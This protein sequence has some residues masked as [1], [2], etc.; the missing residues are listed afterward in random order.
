M[1]FSPF[2]FITSE[3]MLTGGFMGSA[4]LKIDIPNLVGLYQAGKL[5]L[6]ELITGRYPL[7][8]INEAVRSTERG[9]PVRNVIMFYR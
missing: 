3:R 6:D 4:N 2:E 9:E 8:K 5:K 1:S 7:E